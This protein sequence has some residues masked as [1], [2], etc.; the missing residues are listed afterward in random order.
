[1][2]VADSES[3][4]EG[5]SDP[6]VLTEDPT[7][8]DETIVEDDLAHLLEPTEIFLKLAFHQV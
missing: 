5:D 7:T 2:I 3:G 8:I 4:D 1:M 6:V